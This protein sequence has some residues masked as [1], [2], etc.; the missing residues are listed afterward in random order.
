MLISHFLWLII[1]QD[2]GVASVVTE[3][4]ADLS[5]LL[6]PEKSDLELIEAREYLVSFPNHDPVKCHDVRTHAAC[7][8]SREGKV[9]YS[10]DDQ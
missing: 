2:N 10:D 4:I 6:G 7:T 9:F 3:F 1:A 8:H 5:R